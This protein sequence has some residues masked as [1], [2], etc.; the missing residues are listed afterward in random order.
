MSQVVAEITPIGLSTLRY[1][2]YVIYAVINI[3]LTFPSK[4][5]SSS[6]LSST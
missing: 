5:Y 2:Y 4:S 6:D 1:K 3:C